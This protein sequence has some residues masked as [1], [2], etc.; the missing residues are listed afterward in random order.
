[1]PVEIT[2]LPTSV[3]VTSR[4]WNP[5]EKVASIRTRL[6]EPGLTFQQRLALEAISLL[7]IK[8]YPE[9]IAPK[10]VPEATGQLETKAGRIVR[11]ALE[12]RK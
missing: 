11:E 9:A 5:R 3:R 2:I 4:P 12:G 1:M 7:T 6:A 10:S 8:L